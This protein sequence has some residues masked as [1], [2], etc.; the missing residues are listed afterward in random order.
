MTP[1]Q[2][3]PEQDELMLDKETLKDLEPTDLEAVRGGLYIIPTKG[4]KDPACPGY[5]PLQPAPVLS[6]DCPAPVSINTLTL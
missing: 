6:V 5:T 2:E 3:H 4:L 1:E